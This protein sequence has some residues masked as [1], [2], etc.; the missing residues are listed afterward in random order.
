ML[1]IPLIALHHSISTINRIGRTTIWLLFPKA[2]CNSHSSTVD[3]GY[4]SEVGWVLFVCHF[5]QLWQKSVDGIFY[6]AVGDEG[7]TRIY[8]WL[9]CLFGPKRLVL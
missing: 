1:W 9:K 5:F 6:V 7:A 3:V 2:D 4:C 8:I